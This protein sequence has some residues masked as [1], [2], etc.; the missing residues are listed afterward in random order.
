MKQT[1]SITRKMAADQEA[2][3]KRRAFIA[4]HGV[5]G[6]TLDSRAN[7]AVVYRLYTETKA[8]LATLVLRYF[9]GATFISTSGMYQGELEAGTVIEIIGSA[10][11]LQSIVHLAGD[12][13]QVNNQ[14]SVLVTWNNASLLNVTADV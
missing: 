4:E 2:H 14:S 6:G 10:A 7:Q 5:T 8:G 3:A 1:S 9:P 12:I 13:R 11:D